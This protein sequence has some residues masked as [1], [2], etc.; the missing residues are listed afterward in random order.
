VNR[1]RPAHAARAVIALVV[2]VAACGPGGSDGPS[3][4]ATMPPIASPGSSPQHTQAISASPMPTTSTLPLTGTLYFGRFDLDL[5]DMTVWVSDADGSNARLFVPGSRLVSCV[6]PGSGQVVM[7]AES[8]DGRIVPS[9]ADADGS[10]FHEL[11]IPDDT[12]NLGV[13]ACSPDGSEIVAEGWD[14]T[15]PGR[16]GL[17][18][19]SI[20]GS[21]LHR[22]TKAGTGA[23][24]IPG[25]Y[26]ADDVAFLRYRGEEP[27]SLHVVSID[28]SRTRPIGDGAY[29][30]GPACSPNGQTLL[31]EAEG[32]LYL[33][34]SVD[35]RETEL[36]STAAGFA[37]AHKYG[38]WFAQGGDVVLF[39]MQMPGPYHDL[40]AMRLDATGLTRITHHP[41]ADNESPRWV[42][43]P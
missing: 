23:H 11:T 27:G 14:D 35:G 1:Q 3:G 38:P 13:A 37:S 4:P 10:N 29:G 39:A 16:T 40:Y 20:D 15:N 32:S 43:A 22:L 7:T 26:L 5:M 2:V 12:L 21:E 9:V 8:D 6:L 30:T 19:L 25:C 42:A 18:S 28:G 31:V 41:Q 34:S 36:T 24:D 17:Y 33:V